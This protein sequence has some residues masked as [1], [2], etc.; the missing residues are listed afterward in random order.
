MQGGGA[1]CPGMAGC[2]EQDGCGG[3]ELGASRSSSSATHFYRI[4]HY[5]SIYLTA[6]NLE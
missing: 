6:P 1:A 4:H 5:L 2:G 3:G